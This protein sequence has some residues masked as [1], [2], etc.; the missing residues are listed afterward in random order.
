MPRKRWAPSTLREVWA[1]RSIQS[2][3]PT[4]HKSSRVVE[5]VFGWVRNKNWEAIR[6]VSVLLRG[7]TVRLPRAFPKKQMGAPTKLK[8][9]APAQVL[10]LYER[11]V[12]GLKVRKEDKGSWAAVAKSL[13][14]ENWPKD[15]ALDVHRSKPARGALLYI[16]RDKGVS[17]RT[18][19]A[20]LARAKR[21][22]TEA[23]RLM[24]RPL[25]E[26]FADFLPEAPI[27]SG[28]EDLSMIAAILQSPD[29]VLSTDPDHQS[30]S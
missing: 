19:R 4:A 24:E 11:I 25:A 12:S 22:R 27:L 5:C 7:E 21:D 15:A 9:M 16:C 3:P 6:A 30:L 29:W 20:V 10:D 13:R 23:R 17:E 8:T 28:P 2:D 1:L 18:L 26:V 14:E